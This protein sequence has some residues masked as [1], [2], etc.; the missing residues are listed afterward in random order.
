MTNDDIGA[1]ILKTLRRLVWATGLLYAI[2]IALI[3]VL[4]LRSISTSEQANRTTKALCIFRDDI[5]SRIDQTIKFLAEHPEGFAGVSAATL[6]NG[7]DGQR[8]TVAALS[9]LDCT[10]EQG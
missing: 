4:A 9:V 10:A 5:Q 3:A 6:R 1:Q 2:V 7:L 8:R